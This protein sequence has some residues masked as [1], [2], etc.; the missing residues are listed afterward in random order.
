MELLHTFGPWCSTAA[1]LL[2]EQEAEVRVLPAR[3]VS[4]ADARRLSGT[5]EV[6]PLDPGSNAKLGVRHAPHDREI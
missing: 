3:L 2:R 6:R 1:P 5:H 4:R